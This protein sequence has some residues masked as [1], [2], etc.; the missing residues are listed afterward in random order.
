MPED[1]VGVVTQALAVR[2]GRM[3]QMVNHS[4]GWVR[5]E[6]LVPARGLIGFRT[7]FLTET[8]GTGL[9]HHVFDRWEPWAGDLRMRPT[10]SLVADRQGKTAAFA[11][12]GLQER[13]MLFV[14]PG[15]DVYEGMIVG[16]NSRAE[17]IDVN[18]IKEKQ[19]TNVRAA[20]ADQLIRLV[21]AKRLSLEEAIEFIRADEC[22]E[23]TPESVR[24]RKNAA[25]S[26]RPGEGRPAGR[27]RRLSAVRVLSRL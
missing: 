7:E 22:V 15:E 8:R 21:P 16:E 19:Q 9:M 17:D 20:A 10:G 13:G 14:G 24:P 4:T 27:P 1:F 5:L 18:A 3:E 11:L 25:R 12:F 26:D 6:F 23:I 2:K